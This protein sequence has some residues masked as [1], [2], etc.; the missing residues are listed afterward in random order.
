MLSTRTLKEYFNAPYAMQHSPCEKVIQGMAIMCLPHLFT[1]RTASHARKGASQLWAS[2][3]VGGG[4]LFYKRRG[5][6][7][8]IP[9]E[10]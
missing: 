6:V 9:A 5:M 8:T 7:V 4:Q 3:V 1:L 10:L 2:Q